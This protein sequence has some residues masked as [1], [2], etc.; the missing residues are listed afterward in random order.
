L[1]IETLGH[2]WLRDRRILW[3]IVVITLMLSIIQGYN[4]WQVRQHPD[5]RVNIYRAIGTWLGAHTP[6][7]AV[8]GTLEVGIIGYYAE[9][10]MVDFAGLI[11]PEVAKHLTQS[12]TYEDAALWAI[13]RYQP[14]YVVLRKGDFGHLRQS[15]IES[16]CHLTKQFSGEPFGSNTDYE[17]F[18][19]IKSQ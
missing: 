14:D 4:S 19:C 5:Q 15:Y 18:A 10:P 8:I 9:R 7:D 17:I 6:A 16:H 3:V 13:E 11:Q 12:T 2:P 1:G